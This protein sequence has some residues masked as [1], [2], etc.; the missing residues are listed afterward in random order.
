MENESQQVFNIIKRNFELEEADIAALSDIKS[1]LVIRI[2]EMLDK[3]VE[4]L[5]SIVY[6]IDISQK[7]I[8]AIF[9]NLSKDDIASEI[10]DAVIERQLMKVQTRKLYKS[11]IN[12][13]E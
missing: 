8:D 10:A 9:D 2:R 5:L 7:K 11:N 4:K 6:R 1:I 12:K 3:N 13:I